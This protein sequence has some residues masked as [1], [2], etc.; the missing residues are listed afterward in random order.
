MENGEL[1]TMSDFSG[2][3]IYWLGIEQQIGIMIIIN[4][5]DYMS[6]HIIQYNIKLRLNVILNV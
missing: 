3:I 5:Y 1:Y 6:I 2:Q 4:N